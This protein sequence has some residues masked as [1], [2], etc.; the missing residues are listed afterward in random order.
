MKNNNNKTENQSKQ[1][2][3]AARKIKSEELARA[4]LIKAF[5]L[6]KS[7]LLGAIVISSTGCMQLTGAKRIDLWGAKFEANTGFEVSAGVQQYD[8][9]LDRKGMNVE[10]TDSKKIERY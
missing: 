9:V 1:R 10:A 6:R 7:I 5:K 4:L 8:H 2:L 3:D